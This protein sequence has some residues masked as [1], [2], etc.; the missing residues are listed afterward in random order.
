[1]APQP[2]IL[3][4]DEP[5]NHL[6]L[7]TIEWLEEELARSSSRRHRHFAR[8][9]VPRTGVARHGL[10][11]PRPARGGWTRA[12]RHFE[13]WRDEMLEEE[14]REQ[15]KLGRQIVREEHWLRYGV[16]ARR[17][18]NMRRLGE[19]QALRSRFRGHRGAEGAGDAGGR[20]CRRIRQAGDRGEEH[21]QELRRP[22]LSS[23]TSRRASSAAT[24]SAWSARTAPARRRS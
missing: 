14:E 17:K 16:T 19:L 7:Q 8:P 5:T 6:D 3:L 2:D 12:L 22:A 15:H 9:P 1:M 23:A 4:L 21:L 13:A 24:A 11:R 18:R 10:A 20:R